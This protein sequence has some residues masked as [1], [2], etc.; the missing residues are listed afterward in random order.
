[1]H[2]VVFT[3]LTFSALEKSK[4]PRN[5][6]NVG[7]LT[8]RLLLHRIS[9]NSIQGC[10][11]GELSAICAMLPICPSF[12]RRLRSKPSTTQ[13]KRTHFQ[14]SRGIHNW[15]QE[16]STDNVQRPHSAYSE[17]QAFMLLVPTSK[18]LLT[19]CTCLIY[20]N[21]RVENFV[22]SISRGRVAHGDRQYHNQRSK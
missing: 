2:K 20:S 18:V 16:Y 3:Q 14:N 17:Q 13:H 15:L 9:E 6:R 7:R 8:C 4:A 1:M 5:E 22:M 10:G 21:L 12:V 19:K 11:E